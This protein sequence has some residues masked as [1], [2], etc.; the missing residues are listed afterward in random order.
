MAPSH[1]RAIAQYR[2]VHTQDLLEY[3]STDSGRLRPPQCSLRAVTIS[4]E[5]ASH[6]LSVG[7]ARLYFTMPASHQKSSILY[8]LRIGT[9]HIT[10]AGPWG[11]GVRS[12]H[13]DGSMFIRRMTLCMHCTFLSILE[14]RSRN[15]QPTT[16]TLEHNQITGNFTVRVS[17]DPLL[18]WSAAGR[19][20]WQYMRYLAG[21]Y[22][23]LDFVLQFI[24]RSFNCTRCDEL[25]CYRYDCQLA[26]CPDRDIL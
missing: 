5:L 25:K 22:S 9:N 21:M 23:P 26:K 11:K 18:K 12:F 8:P 14:T 7:V 2:I 20:T 3:Q 19:S 17:N 24:H 10:S 6:M 4:D 13:P 16:V 1:W 15:L